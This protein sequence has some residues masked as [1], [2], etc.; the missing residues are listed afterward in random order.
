MTQTWVSSFHRAGSTNSPLSIATLSPLASA[1]QNAIYGLS[2]SG[3]GGAPPYTWSLVGQIG[4]NAWSVSPAGTVSGIPTTV[5]TDTLSIKVTDSIGTSVTNVFALGVTPQLAAA[6]PVFTPGAGSYGA[7]QFVVISC[8]TAGSTCYYTLDGSAPTFPVTGTTQPYT[9]GAGGLIV[10]SSETIRAIGT[11]PGLANSAIASAGYVIGLP[12][13]ATPTFSPVAGTYTSV[14][15]VTVSCATPSST[16]YYTLDGTTPTFPVTG[17]T[18]QYVGPVAVG[19]SETMRAIGTATGFSSSVVGSA[20]YVINLPISANAFKFNPGD[21]LASEQDENST[22]TAQWQSEIQVLQGHGTN[23]Q[24]YRLCKQ[25]FDLENML[26]TSNAA[27]GAAGL[28]GAALQAAINAQYP[29]FADTE[30]CFYYLQALCPGKR[31]MKYINHHDISSFSGPFIQSTNYVTNPQIVPAWIANGGVVDSGVAGT[32]KIP[33]FYGA[34]GT[35]LFSGPIDPFYT[36][37]SFYGFAFNGLNTVNNTMVYGVPAFWNPCVRQAMVQLVQAFFMR[38]L[39]AGAAYSSGTAYTR[40]NVV[41]SGGV[42]YLCIANT[43]GN[44]PPN[45]T[46]WVVNPWAGKTFDDPSVPFEMSGSNMEYSFDFTNVTNIAGCLYQNPP[47]FAAGPQATRASGIAGYKALFKA[48]CAASPHTIVDTCFS[49]S[50]NVVSPFDTPVTMGQHTNSLIT[51]GEVDALNT[52]RG[53]ALGNSNHYAN[54]FFNAFLSGTTWTATGPEQAYLGVDVPVQGNNGLV[55]P[56]PNPAHSL[57]GVIPKVDQ[58]QLEDYWERL[59]PG[60]V[61]DSAGVINELI[62]TDAVLGAQ[63]RIWNITTSRSGSPF[64]FSPTWWTNVVYPAIQANATKASTTLP[65]SLVSFDFFISPTGSNL[66]TGTSTSSPWAITAINTKQSTY[67]GKNVGLMPGTYDVSGLMSTTQEVVLQINGGLSSATPTYVASCNSSG[68]YQQGAAVIDAF[69][70]SGQYGGGSANLSYVM[71]QSQSGTAP[72][73]PNL[74]NFTIDGLTF[75]GFSNWAVSVGNSSGLPVHIPNWAVQNCTFMNS[76]CTITTTHPAPLIA[77]SWNNGL[78]SNCWFYN[79][80]NTA[81]DENHYSSINAWGF[82]TCSG[83]IIEKCTFV[84]SPGIYMPMDNGVSQNVTVRQCYFDF[85]QTSGNFTNTLAIKGMAPISAGATLGGAVHH[86]VIKGGS[87]QDSLTAGS[88]FTPFAYYNNTYDI[89]GGT[90]NRGVAFR[91]IESAGLSALMSCYNNLIYDNGFS[92]YGAGTYGY[93]SCSINGFALCDYNVYGSKATSNMFTTFSSAGGTGG[94]VAYN[95]LTAWK[96][97]IGNL[98]AHSITNAVNPFAS[99]GINALAYTTPSG[100]AFQAGRVGGVSSGAV[101]NAGAWDGAVT[102]VGCSFA[103]SR[104]S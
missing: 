77:Y 28:T 88:W 86:N 97:A 68:V 21:Y 50:F 44:A 67:A 5:E 16:I 38:T 43:T 33:D 62:A 48:W 91:N 31:L 26:A 83:L 59:T 10:N 39:S 42:N 61:D 20:A 37:S 51:G 53:L 14:Q 71:G 47:H 95:S 69:G 63:Y 66:N 70:A 104:I 55:M 93:N 101:C 15:S 19:T 24:G 85:T 49:F 18:Q 64:A 60:T 7:T 45:A 75:S 78:I 90:A 100:P 35:S 58:H 103:D 94:E 99:A 57:V 98:D 92:G 73:P 102:Q 79:N 3:S 22:P 23:I 12:S 87:A 29:G 72:Q 36:G 13:A 52:I 65:S 27:L 41:T 89:A 4:S 56:A 6:L 80:K 2:M 9:Q 81:A 32:L 46:F 34:S 25:W 84:N 40:G 96:T 82:S 11:A 8:A 17:T 74:G 1:V 76:V 30:A 54:N